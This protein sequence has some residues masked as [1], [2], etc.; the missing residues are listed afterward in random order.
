[1]GG[2]DLANQFRES[3]E[4]HRITLRVWWPLFYWLIDV[5]CINAYRLYQ[6]YQVQLGG[7]PFSHLEFRVQLINRLLEYSMQAKLRYL[8][9]NMGGQRLFSPEFSNI[10]CQIRYIT[11]ANC[12]WCSYILKRQKIIN[13]GAIIKRVKR[14]RGGC[15]FCNIA[16]CIKGGCWSSYHSN[17]ANY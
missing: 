12:A 14:S 1:M 15:G 13:K 5:A 6:L 11:P 10:H 17:N 7:K 3:Y 16:L 8:Q 4:T 2:V 9:I